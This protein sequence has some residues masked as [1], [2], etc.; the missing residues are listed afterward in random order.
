MKAPCERQ[1]AGAGAGEIRRVNTATKQP[2]PD[3]CHPHLSGQ[4]LPPWAER[5]CQ[6]RPGG[7]RERGGGGK[8]LPPAE[9]TC[10]KVLKAR[11]HYYSPKPADQHTHTQQRGGRW[12]VGGTFLRAL[13]G[14]KQLR[15]QAL[16]PFWAPE[17]SCICS[18][19]SVKSSEVTPGPPAK[20]PSYVTILSF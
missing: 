3:I 6:V 2:Q 19:A 18:R 20:K 11:R 12:G 8:G 16:V 7:W 17:S 15:H 4:P 13:K 10:S 5:S 9:G 14:C 1:R